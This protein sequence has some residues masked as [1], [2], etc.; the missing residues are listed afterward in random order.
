MAR[1]KAVQIGKAGGDFEIVERDIPEPSKNQVRIRVEACGMCHSD[2]LVKE[3]HWP[4]IKYPRIPG[5][6]IAGRID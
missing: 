5:H 3:G 6:E 2:A 1:M 4:G